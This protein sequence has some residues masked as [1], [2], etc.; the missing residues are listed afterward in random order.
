MKQVSIPI[1]KMQEPSFEI[2]L[3]NGAVLT[4]R[5]VVMAAF[6]HMTDDDKPITDNNRHAIIALNIQQ[7]VAVIKN[8]VERSEMN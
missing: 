3:A 1:T 7:L 6:Q 2:T 4:I 8:P 5:T